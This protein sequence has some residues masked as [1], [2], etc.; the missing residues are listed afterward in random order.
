MTAKQQADLDRRR[1]GNLYRVRLNEETSRRL[2]DYIEANNLNANKALNIIL[3]DFF[4]TN[5]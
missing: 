3:S 4:K 5:D 1:A 2:R